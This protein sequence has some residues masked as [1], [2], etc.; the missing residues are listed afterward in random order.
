[1]STLSRKNSYAETGWGGIIPPCLKSI[2]L[3]IRP[4]ASLSGQFPSPFCSFRHCCSL[5][6]RG[7]PART[8]QKSDTSERQS[9]SGTR[10]S[11]MCFMSIRRSSVLSLVPPLF[12]SPRRRTMPSQLR[13]SRNR[14]GNRKG[15]SLCLRSSHDHYYSIQCT[16]SVST[17]EN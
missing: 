11:S 10:E 7:Q 12:C 1:M 15:V 17:S 14:P 9:I 6:F 8:A 2:H 4:I 3:P 16:S 5:I 13:H